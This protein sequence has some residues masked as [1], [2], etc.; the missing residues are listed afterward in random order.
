MFLDA[1]AQGFS[2]WQWLGIIITFCFAIEVACAETTTHLP[3]VIETEESQAAAVKDV[4]L[5]LGL[6]F[7]PQHELSVTDIATPEKLAQFQALPA[8]HVSVGYTDATVWLSLHAQ[9]NHNHSEPLFISIDNPLLQQV[10]CYQLPSIAQQ[11]VYL[12]RAGSQVAPAQR[13]FFATSIYFPL[14]A[15][16]TETAQYLCKI[17]SQTSL[18]MP[19]AVLP[20]SAVA[21]KIYYEHFWFGFVAGLLLLLF[22]ANIFVCVLNR[23]RANAVYAVFILSILLLF[24]AVTGVGHSY[25]WPATPDG[26]HRMVPFSIALLSLTSYLFAREYFRLQCP[27]T[28]RKILHLGAITSTGVMFLAFWLP[29]A[30]ATQ[31]AM[32]NALVMA[33]VLL[34]YAI[35]CCVYKFLG[36][37]IFLVG[38]L[39]ILMTGL[40]QLS[41][42]LGFIP[43]FYAVEYILF[44]GAIME[45]IVLSGGFVIKNRKIEQKQ[46]QTAQQMLSHTEASLV[47]ISAMNQRLAEQISEREQSEK[48]QKALFQ[49]SE[50]SASDLPMPSFLRQLHHVVENLMFAKNFYVAL[51]DRQQDSV[52]FPYMVDEVDE[53]L[54]LP[55]QQI[56]APLLAGSWTMWILTHGKPLFGDATTI[57]AMTGLEPRFGAVAICWL[58]LPLF[59]G[60]DRL[61][62]SEAT[63]DKDQIFGVLC[64]QIYDEHPP[65]TQAEYQLLDYVSRHISQALLRQR[66]RQELKAT[67]EERTAAY[68]QSLQQVQNLLNNTGQ[69]FLSCDASLQIQPQY[70]AAC[71][72]IFRQPQLSGDLPQL[73]SAQDPKLIALYRDVLSEVLQAPQADGMANLYLSLLPAEREF[74]QQYYQMCYRKLGDDQLMVIM[75]DIT[76][77]RTLQRAL[78]Q[79]Q[80]EAQFIVYA[81]KHRTEVQQTLRSFAKF[82]RDFQPDTTLDLSELRRQ[83][84][85]FKGLLAQI[86]CPA[87]PSLLHDT[88]DMLLSATDSFSDSST[89][90]PLTAIKDALQAGWQQVELVLQQYLSSQFLADEAILQV[91]ESLMQQLADALPQRTD[92]TAAILRLRFQPLSD[93]LS[94]PLAA[95]QRLA[96]SQQKEL[97]LKI[98]LN[99]QLL[100]DPDYY[101]SLLAVLPHLLRNA[102]DHGVETPAERLQHG[103]SALATLKIT[104]QLFEPFN[105]IEPAEMPPWL[106]LEIQDDGQGIAMALLRQRVQEQQLVLATELATMPDE[107]LIDFIFVDQLSTRAEANFISGRGIGLAAVRQEI[108]RYDGRIY[109]QSQV[110]NGTRFVIEIPLQHGH[111]SITTT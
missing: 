109:A 14:P 18:S 110:G 63:T 16:Q 77:E 31:L 102:V 58:G 111:Y 56:P 53:V 21:T 65:Y 92:L 44:I 48:V 57:T 1:G 96:T 79:Q 52:C 59:A 97:Q 42:T 60:Q 99:E 67:V 3:N 49:I 10:D 80:T 107:Q 108:S 75:T 104:A 15:Q 89:A 23:Q 41:K 55:D 50:L 39:L 71:L 70:S 84:H 13:L 37:P 38:R 94:L 6:Y 81:L 86:N 95:A 45:G 11:P 72:D 101:Q 27:P 25:L 76:A 9:F 93:L 47:S 103:K 35:V 24:F 7:D 88:E 64:L 87:L 100:F 66:Y 40:G 4:R 74:H 5:S 82:L 29:Y 8:Q 85:T 2:R 54:P 26:L 91:P 30:V 106:R 73:L 62:A 61:N 19:I 28:W 83:L 20:A 68:R 98:E 105:K 17:I 36:A 34:I 12:G 43:A 22:I 78:Q 51:Y 90:K 33:I 32:L 69:G 46:H